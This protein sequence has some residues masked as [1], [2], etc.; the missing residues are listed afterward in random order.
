M[1]GLKKESPDNGQILF[2]YRHVKGLPSLCP[3]KDPG[4]YA[5]LEQHFES[6][7]LT[8]TIRCWCGRTA[9]LYFDSLME[10]AEF[11]KKNGVG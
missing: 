10:K 4:N 2:G 9:T 3:C 1:V 8:C 6:E 11:L 7:P 5:S